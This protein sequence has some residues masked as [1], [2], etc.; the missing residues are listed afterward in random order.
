MNQIMKVMEKMQARIDKSDKK[1]V[2]ATPQNYNKEPH[3]NETEDKEQG[4][5]KKGEP[6]EVKKGEEEEKSTPS[7]FNNSFNGYAG[8]TSIP[9]R[10]LPP[11]FT[12]PGIKFHGTKNPNHH[13]RNFINA[14]TLKGIDKDMFNSIFL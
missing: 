14:M 9:K 11:K 1:M 3:A 12:I 8:F 4:E 5:D 10:K 6:E 13:I 7:L 2:T